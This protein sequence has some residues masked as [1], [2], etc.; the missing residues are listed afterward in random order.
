VTKVV[1]SEGTHLIEHEVGL[2]VDLTRD[3][4]QT[5][6]EPAVVRFGLENIVTAALLLVE[7]YPAEDHLPDLVPKLRGQT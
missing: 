1:A 2:G 3:Q 7:R 4:L 6:A 5:R